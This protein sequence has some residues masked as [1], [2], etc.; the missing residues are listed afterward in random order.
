[1]SAA[2]VAVVASRLPT[3]PRRIDASEVIVASLG[4][5]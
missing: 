5:V 1:M 2:A 4:M 3:F